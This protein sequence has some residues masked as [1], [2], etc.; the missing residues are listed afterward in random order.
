MND[1]EFHVSCAILEDCR[2]LIAAGKAQRWDV[3]KWAVTV[4]VGL[5]TA[6]IALSNHPNA[7]YRL[8]EFAIGVAV[9]AWLLVLHYNN[10]MKNARNDS[11]VTELYLMNNDIDFAAITGGGPQRVGFFYDWQEL[12]LFSFILF[13]SIIPALIIWKSGIG[14]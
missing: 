3:I 8:Y 13:T 5:A 7:G 14:R 2:K 1:H 6:S 9:I 4:N 12:V 10:R 11:V